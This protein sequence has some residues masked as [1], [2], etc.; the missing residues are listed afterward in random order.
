LHKPLLPLVGSLL[1]GL[2]LEQI[3]QLDG[4]RFYDPVAEKVVWEGIP[5]ST[6]AQ[7]GA[8]DSSCCGNF[9]NS[10]SSR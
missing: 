5:T 3:A 4:L 7:S 10:D 1:T 9:A 8:M 2:T 6:P